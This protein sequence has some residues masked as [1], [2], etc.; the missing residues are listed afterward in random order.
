VS[1]EMAE[2]HARR[3]FGQYEAQSR[4]VEAAQPTGDFDKAV[5]RIN[6]LGGKKPEDTKMSAG[7]SISANLKELGYGG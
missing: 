6:E 7:R 2:E 5:E 4:A 1:H 3:A